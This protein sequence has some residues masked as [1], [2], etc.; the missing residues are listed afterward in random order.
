MRHHTVEIV[1][2]Q[3]MLKI[4]CFAPSLIS[5][6]ISRIIGTGIQ[7]GI[8]HTSHAMFSREIFAAC[9]KYAAFVEHPI[10]LQDFSKAI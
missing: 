10:W 5:I 4:P 9:L 6:I 1:Q 2:Q 8:L 3:N 7:R